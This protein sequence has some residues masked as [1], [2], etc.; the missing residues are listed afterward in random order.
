MVLYSFIH[1]II[2]YATTCR[3]HQ[4]KTAREIAI[5]SM[6]AN[7][8]PLGGALRKLRRQM[9]VRTAQIVVTLILVYI[10]AWTPYAIVTLIEQ[11]AP[12]SDNDYY[13]SLLLP[14]DNNN[15]TDVASAAGSIISC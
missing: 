13:S 6:A 2:Y 10:T 5:V 8:S 14:D 1:S 4:V 7:K 11:F 9:D 3:V 12:I 15:A